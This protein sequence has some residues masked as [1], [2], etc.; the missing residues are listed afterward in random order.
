MGL[1]QNSCLVSKGYLFEQRPITFQSFL[2]FEGASD[3]ERKLGHPQPRKR[4]IEG[5]DEARIYP[6]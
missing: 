6:D 2:D 3:I 4:R 5:K 1:G